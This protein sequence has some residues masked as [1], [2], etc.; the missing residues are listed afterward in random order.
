MTIVEFFQEQRRLKKTWVHG[1]QVFGSIDRTLMVQR[2]GRK[3]D[4]PEKFKLR[5]K[6]V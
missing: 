5:R 3:P 6:L 1:K 4:M 2:W